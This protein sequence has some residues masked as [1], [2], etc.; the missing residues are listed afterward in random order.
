MTRPT[1]SHVKMVT[2][3]TQNIREEEDGQWSR[4]MADGKKVLGYMYPL[5]LYRLSET[6]RIS[7]E[8]G[9]IN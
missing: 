4:C 9:D 2:P 7:L 1:A 5:C 8:L 3:Q 6:I